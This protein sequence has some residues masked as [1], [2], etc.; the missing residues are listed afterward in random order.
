MIAKLAT[1][2]EVERYYFLISTGF[3]EDMVIMPLS[4][5]YGQRNK[6]AVVS[7]GQELQFDIVNSAPHACST[8]SVIMQEMTDANGVLELKAYFVQLL[9]IGFAHCCRFYRLMMN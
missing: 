6:L 3:I 5:I 2:L 1:I 4:S 7:I 8:K 9:C